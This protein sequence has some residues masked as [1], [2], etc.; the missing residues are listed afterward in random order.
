MAK[1][2][3]IVDD[4]AEIQRFIQSSLRMQGYVTLLA[5]NGNEALALIASEQPD[6]VIMDVMM[7]IMDGFSALQLIRS[8]SDTA[9][10]PVIMLTALDKEDSV[11]KGW[12]EG[13]DLYLAKPFEVADLARC[14]EAIF[15]NDYTL[16]P[17][18]PSHRRR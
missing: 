7:P 4:E 16:L 17:A 6:V 11:S 2:I 13:A 5:N 3:L 10:L 18:P 12:R 15:Q 14:L 9:Q 8:N 1:K